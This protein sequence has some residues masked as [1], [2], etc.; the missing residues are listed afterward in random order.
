M[1]Q[2]M[3]TFTNL[4]SM[5]WALSS[6]HISL[7]YRIFW[8]VMV[9][10]VITVRM[11]MTGKRHQMILMS[12]NSSGQHISQTIIKINL[13]F[14][15]SSQTPVLVSKYQ[16]TIFWNYKSQS[17]SIFLPD[18]EL[19]EV[20]SYSAEKTYQGLGSSFGS[21]GYEDILLHITITWSDVINFEDAPW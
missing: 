10:M 13:S 7:F 16:N 18:R 21:K 4:L 3:Q 12:H 1:S 2:T 9:I 11:F 15:F 20:Y 5:K 6:G 8:F 19:T 14:L 17:I